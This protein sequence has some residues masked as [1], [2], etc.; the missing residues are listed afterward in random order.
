LLCFSNRSFADKK[1]SGA[2]VAKEE[3]VSTTKPAKPS[4]TELVGNKWTVE[5]HHNA[6]EPIVIKATARNQ[7]VLIYKCENSVVIIEGKINS[8]AIDG[9]KKVG[10]VFDDC[11]GEWRGGR[12]REVLD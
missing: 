3:K 2:V 7:S 8:I 10:V 12:G 5:W 1:I 6:K 9:C 11:L 4:K